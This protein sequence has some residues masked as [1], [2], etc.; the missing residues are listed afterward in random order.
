[1]TEYRTEYRT[2]YHLHLRPNH[3]VSIAGNVMVVSDRPSPLGGGDGMAQAQATPDQAP[4]HR[5]GAAEPGQRGEERVGG[6]VEPDAAAGAQE[7]AGGAGKR[8]LESDAVYRGHLV[9]LFRSGIAR[10]TMATGDALDKV[11][12]EFLLPRC[13]ADGEVD[14][15]AQPP[16]R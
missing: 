13:Y 6:R 1:M 9:R 8:A 12:I 7:P 5:G 4:E 11:G 3:C 16:A 15:P 10:A 2:E 14:A